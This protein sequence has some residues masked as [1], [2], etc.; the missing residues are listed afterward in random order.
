MDQVEVVLM[1]SPVT[2]EMPVHMPELEALKVRV[3]G[4]ESRLVHLERSPT[5]VTWSSAASV[6]AVE[7]VL[8]KLK[9]IK[10][11]AEVYGKGDAAPVAQAVVR[12]VEEHLAEMKAA[13]DEKWRRAVESLER[14][15][16]RGTITTATMPADGPH[17]LVS[18]GG[19]SV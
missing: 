1:D 11:T 4:L 5:V 6:A 9:A 13:E 12:V 15:T 7:A 3:D 14:N 8:G 10:L 17:A 18:I 2:V 16:G 19:P